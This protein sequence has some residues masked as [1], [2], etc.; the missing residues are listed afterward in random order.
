MR[1]RILVVDNEKVIL[2]VFKEILESKG[3]AV[4]TAETGQEAMEKTKAQ[5]HDLALLDIKLPDIEGTER[6]LKMRNTNPTMIKI[7]ITG[8]A[9]LENAIKSIRL[10]A[11]K[12]LMKPV[13][14]TELLRVVDERL[15]EKEE[16]EAD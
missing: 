3:Y 5:N 15:R 6:L 11:H 10:G 1:K 7:M 13:D 9:S 14:P 8:Y 12:Y 2:A 4:D 16:R